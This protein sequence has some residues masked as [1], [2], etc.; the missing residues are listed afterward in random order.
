MNPFKHPKQKKHPKM[1][2][3]KCMLNMLKDHK[4]CKVRKLEYKMDF[5]VI[6][7]KVTYSM[8]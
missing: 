3:E 2:K 5:G 1:S 6:E 7:S 8:N 4:V